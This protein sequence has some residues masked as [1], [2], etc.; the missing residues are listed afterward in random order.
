MDLLK[1]YLLLQ[2]GASE[3]EYV[4]RQGICIDVPYCREKVEWLTRKMD[5]AE[6]RLKWT[7]LGEAWIR[8]YGDSPS[9]FS[10]DQ[11]R[12]VL[13]DDLKVPPFKQTE[14]GVDSTDEESLRQAEVEGIEHLIKMRKYK[15]VRDVLSGFLRYQVNGVLHP[16][17]QLH[18]VQT[19]R[20]SSADPNMQNVP[21]RDPEATE[22]CRRAIIPRKG[23][24]ILE[25]DYSGLEVMIAACY[26]KDPAMLAYLHDPTSDMHADT[27]KDLFFIRGDTKALKKE[28]N[29]FSVLRYGAKNGFVFPEFYGDFYE[30]CAYYLACRWCKLSHNKDWTPGSGALFN[31]STIGDH[32]LEHG[33]RNLEV[34]TEHVKKVEHQFWNDR[35]PVYNQW[36]KDWY[37]RYTRR[38]FFDM[39]TGFR[40]LGVYGKNAATNYPVQGAAFHCLLKSLIEV[41]REA[42]R[43]KWR[44]ALIGEI[45]DSLL[46][47]VHPDEFDEVVET[48]RDI[49][50]RKLL[51]EWDWINVPLRV[52]VSAGGVDGSWAKMEE[53]V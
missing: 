20:S 31:G 29:G 34:F 5:Q 46:G 2:N 18:T 25:A 11:I 24:R 27:A 9:W 22:I 12:V 49:T 16:S 43:R 48:I 8:R 28:M 36:R 26:H 39:K 40:C 17:F 30:S 38:G 50:S 6:R 1:G 47:D 41:N 44:S 13:F 23:H 37:S 52:E 51:E 14:K 45:H 53:V 7:E 19:Y 10:G 21:H 42:R 15:K 32:L 33:I 4:E 3:L 35:F